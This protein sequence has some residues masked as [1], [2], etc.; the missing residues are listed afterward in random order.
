MKPKSKVLIYCL[1]A[2]C[3]CC[4]AFSA[5]ARIISGYKSVNQSLW[6]EKDIDA[7]AFEYYYK[8]HTDNCEPQITRRSYSYVDES[9]TD[10]PFSSVEVTVRCDH[11][12]YL[13]T[14]DN[15]ADELEAVSHSIIEPSAP[16]WFMLLLQIII[17]AIVAGIIFM[18]KYM[19]KKQIRLL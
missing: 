10:Y 13:I 14:V 8:I 11:G 7:V 1:I 17:V 18:V 19:K 4:L 3:A 6:Y 9:G 2:A 16:I 15:V 12:E 5:V